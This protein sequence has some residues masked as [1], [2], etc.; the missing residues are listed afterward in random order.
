MKQ[1]MIFHIKSQKIRIKIQLL[2]QWKY[3]LILV[4][5]MKDG[6]TDVD[7]MK[8]GHTDVDNMKDGQ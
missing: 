7:N 4:N 5:N 2:L 6:H 1:I 3:G 8:D